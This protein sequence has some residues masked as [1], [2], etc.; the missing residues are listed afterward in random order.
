MTTNFRHESQ[1][2]ILAYSTGTE[3]GHC[4]Y[5]AY[6]EKELKKFREPL[7]IEPVVEHNENG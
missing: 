7:P 6:L 5:I 3:M 4:S 1:S 2:V